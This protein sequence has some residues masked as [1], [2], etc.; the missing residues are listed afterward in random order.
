[1]AKAMAVLL[2]YGNDAVDYAVRAD[3]AVFVREGYW[4]DKYRHWAKTKWARPSEPGHQLYREILAAV[5]FG[6]DGMKIGFGSSYKI[7]RE[8]IGRYRLPEAH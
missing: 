3:G 8:D 7:C 6:E 2:G 5:L 4:N 1:M